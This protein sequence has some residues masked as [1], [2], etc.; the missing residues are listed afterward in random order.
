MSPD[1]PAMKSANEFGLPHV[2]YLG[3]KF[4]Q[5]EPEESWPSDL[6][7]RTIQ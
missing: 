6:N 7:C 4:S 3:G 1:V 5:R 2:V